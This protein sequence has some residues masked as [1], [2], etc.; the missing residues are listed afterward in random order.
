MV[1]EVAESERGDGSGDI[2][3]ELPALVRGH[4]FMSPF[5]GR[6]WVVIGV[7][8][9]GILSGGLTRGLFCSFRSPRPSGS[10][11]TDR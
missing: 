9:G 5:F 6:E 3:Y 11:N 7:L 8:V 10:C 2:G 1:D 4:G